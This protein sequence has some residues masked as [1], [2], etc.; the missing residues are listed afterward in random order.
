MTGE[1]LVAEERLQEIVQGPRRHAEMRR[2]SAVEGVRDLVE[3]V[4][5]AP[6]LDEQ[7]GVDRMTDRLHDFD[8]S[9][10]AND[11]PLAIGGERQTDLRRGHGQ[12][13]VIVVRHADVDLA[14]AS[15]RTSRRCLRHRTPL[16]GWVRGARM[17]DLTG[18]GAGEERSGPPAEWDLLANPH[19]ATPSFMLRASFQPP[20]FPL[21][22]ILNLLLF[23][24]AF[25]NTRALR[26]IA[27]IGAL[28]GSLA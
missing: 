22:V 26:N 24:A 15:L 21:A 9:P 2:Q 19:L 11:E 5:D 17:R 4:A 18:R 20:A 16:K 10:W 1:E 25:G 8:A 27:A 7:H 23:A 13:R 6:Q 3:V 14:V 12:S 28:C